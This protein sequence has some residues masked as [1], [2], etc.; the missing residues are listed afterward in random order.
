MEQDSSISFIDCLSRSPL[1]VEGHDTMKAQSYLKF[2][3]GEMEKEIS[4]IDAATVAF[5]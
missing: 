2:L 5:Q 4:R 3:G 1:F